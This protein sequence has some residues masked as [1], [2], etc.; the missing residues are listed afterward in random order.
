MDGSLLVLCTYLLFKCCKV[1]PAH[2]ITTVG[3]FACDDGSYG[4]IPLQYLF[5][6]LTASIYVAVLVIFYLIL[7]HDKVVSSHNI[8]DVVK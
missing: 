8:C 7:K 2:Y 3:L 5:I 6:R 4:S 1:N